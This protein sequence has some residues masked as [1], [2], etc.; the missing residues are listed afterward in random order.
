MTSEW[1]YSHY[2][3]GSYIRKYLVISPF[4][5]YE[6]ELDARCFCRTVFVILLSIFVHTPASIRA[7]SRT[8]PHVLM[9]KYWWKNKKKPA[10]LLSAMWR[11]STIIADFCFW[12]TQLLYR[13]Y[14]IQKRCYT[15]ALIGRL[16]DSNVSWI[17]FPCITSFEGSQPKFHKPG[18]FG[19]LDS[20]HPV[21]VSMHRMRSEFEFVCHMEIQT[22]GGKVV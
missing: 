1:P 7:H 19:S 17:M 8:L 11:S 5:Q 3:N 2:D 21:P 13:L 9:H 20:Y 14:R 22:R 4:F 6:E 12:E 18:R 10:R 16:V 15:L